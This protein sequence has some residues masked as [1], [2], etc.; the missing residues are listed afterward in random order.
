M[1]DWIVIVGLISLIFALWFGIPAVMHNCRLRNMGERPLGMFSH[2]PEA[3]SKR[4]HS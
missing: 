3:Q 2:L 1:P 4:D